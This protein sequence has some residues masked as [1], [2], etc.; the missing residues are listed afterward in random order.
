MKGRKTIEL[1]VN[2]VKFEIV[3]ERKVTVIKGDSGTGK[4][5]FARAVRL[6]ST[7]RAK[8][9]CNCK[10]LLQFVSGDNSEWETVIRKCNE[11]IVV[12]DE[13]AGF[14]QTKEF[15]SVVTESNCYFILVTRSGRM[16]YLTYSL[17]SIYEMVTEKSGTSYYTKLYSRYYNQNLHGTVQP[18]LVVTEDSKSGYQMFSEILNCKVVSGFGKDKITNAIREAINLYNSIYVIV[19]GAAFGNCIG[20]LVSL[21]QLNE[22]KNIVVFAPESFEYLLLNIGRF[23]TLAGDKLINTQDYADVSEYLT[24]EQF[25]TDLLKS[26]CPTVIK[27]NYRKSKLSVQLLETKYKEGIKSQLVDLRQSVFKT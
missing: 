14:V 20:G 5:T 9:V 26:L 13:D 22:T 6:L 23:K 19:D 7:G 4:T 2:K 25:Y 12:I 16:G 1:K 18:D 11:K 15:A 8:V 27:D 21:M 17:E 24:W 3:V 10:E